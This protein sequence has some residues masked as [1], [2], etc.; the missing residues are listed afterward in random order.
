MILFAS[1]DTDL[2]ATLTNRV[3]QIDFDSCHP[4]G[5]PLQKGVAYGSDGSSIT[6]SG[7]A[8]DYLGLDNVANFLRHKHGRTAGNHNTA[9]ESPGPQREA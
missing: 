1:I 7:E 3:L 9:R 8:N 6:V 2:L 5:E 4:F